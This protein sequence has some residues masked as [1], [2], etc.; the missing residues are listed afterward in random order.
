MLFTFLAHLFVF[1][2]NRLAPF[3]GAYKENEKEA[4]SKIN[5]SGFYTFEHI[6]I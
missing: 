1:V 4:F 6:L 3:I 2:M 5:I